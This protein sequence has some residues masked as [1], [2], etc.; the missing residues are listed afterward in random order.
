MRRWSDDTGHAALAHVDQL[1][2]LVE[3]A[4]TRGLT[5]EETD[6]FVRALRALG[7]LLPAPDLVPA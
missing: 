6:Q 5:P 2:R 4:V 1:Q 7:E 3:A